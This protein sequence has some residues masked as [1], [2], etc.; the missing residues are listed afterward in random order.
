MQVDNESNDTNMRRLM[1][2]AK[3]SIRAIEIHCSLKT[4]IWVKKE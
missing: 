3:V 1:T 4:I 2:I